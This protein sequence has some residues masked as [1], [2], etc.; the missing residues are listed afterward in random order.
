MVR[1][2]MAIVT[3]LVIY[4]SYVYILGK[5]YYAEAHE[6]LDR[7]HHRVDSMLGIHED[8]HKPEQKGENCGE[9]Q[10]QRTSWYF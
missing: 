10:V 3:T 2:I 6:Y 8:E 9:T 7:L 5:P 1:A 4:I